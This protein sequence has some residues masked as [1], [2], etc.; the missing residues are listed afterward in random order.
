VSEVAGFVPALSAAKPPLFQPLRLA[1]R[2]ESTSQGT[3]MVSITEGPKPLPATLSQ[4]RRALGFALP[5][6][7]TIM[8]ILLLT[9]AVAVVSAVEPLVMKYI[10]DGLAAEGGLSVVWVGLAFLA[11]LAICRDGAGGVSNWLTWRIRVRLQYALL[12]ATVGRLHRMPLKMQRSEG[13]GA[14]LTKLDRS[15]QGFVAAVT[16]LLFSVLPAVVFL[17]MALIIMFDLEWRLALLVLVF[18]PLP[19]LLAAM[20]APEQTRRE[21]NMLDRWAQIYSRF[22]EVLAGL[23]TVRSFAMEEAEKERFLK[24]VNEANRVVER[25]VA[26]DTAFGTASNLVVAIAR[27]AVVGVG[28]A[29]I[30]RGQM[31]IGTLIAFLGYVG[32]L[33]GPVQGLSATYQSLQRATVSLGQIFSILDLQE[34]LGDSPDARDLHAVRGDVEFGNVHFS[35]GPAERPLLNGIS[36]EVSAGETLAVVGPSGSGKTTLMALLMRFYDPDSGAVLLDGQ[37]LRTLKQSSLRRHI[38][39]VLQDPLL[40][41]DTVRA[42]I[43]Y[44]RPDASQAEIERAARAACAHDFI[45]LLPEGY[46]TMVGERGTRLSPGER[47]RISIARALVKQPSIVVLDEA[48]ASLDAE[49]EAAVQAALSTLITNRTTFVI[50]HRLSTVVTADRIVVLQNGR[51]TESGSHEQLIGSGGYYAQLVRQQTRGLIRNE[52]E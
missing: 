1:R 34:H 3:D 51:I 20:A 28:G 47:Q 23:V 6:R 43:A 4:L 12:E 33:F 42:N 8:T 25:G 19:A 14:I 10:V 50:A 9:L 11:I 39:V 29:L 36:L 17:I 16:Q 31:T 45:R 27:I 49:S 26:T 2:P 18:A 35:Y 24:G 15:I 13:V 21:R 52:G 30:V 32:G 37:D 22:N 5:Y 40:F 46:E 7:L 38:G 41:N 48:T 44:A